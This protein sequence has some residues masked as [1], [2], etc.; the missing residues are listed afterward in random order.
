M[1]KYEWE[2]ELRKNLYRIPE[3]EQE[4]V[5]E[6]YNELFLDKVEQGGTEQTIIREFGNPFDVANRILADYDEEIGNGSAALRQPTSFNE[7]EPRIVWTDFSE[8]EAGT[9]AESLGKK[10]GAKR[11]KKSRDKRRFDGVKAILVLV[12]AVII[13]VIVL[14]I[15]VALF[16]VAFSLFISGGAFIIGGIGGVVMSLF[17]L[18]ASVPVAFA[19][20]SACVALAGLGL[21]LLPYCYRGS[22]AL[23]KW[24]AKV[25]KKFFVV[26]FTSRGYVSKESE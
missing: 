11:T 18:G 12:P 9:E 3:R 6:Y 15:G 8:A 16:A 1:T 14:T 24:T 5:F 13:A 17:E 26:A 19:Q 22:I 20:I 25:L 21:I 4:K 2:S 7:P 10:K 23:A